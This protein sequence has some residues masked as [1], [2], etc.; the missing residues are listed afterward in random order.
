MH[1]KICLKRIFGERGL[2]LKSI[3]QNNKLIRLQKRHMG[4]KSDK[5]EQGKKK[6]NNSF[7]FHGISI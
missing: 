4:A 1:G 2:N 3:V 5:S 6:E 7:N